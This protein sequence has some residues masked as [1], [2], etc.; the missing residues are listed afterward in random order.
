MSADRP[1]KLT[2]EEANEA[3]YLITM[4]CGDACPIVA[5]AM[6]DHWTM[7]D[8]KSRD[9]DHVRAIRDAIKTVYGS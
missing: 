4:G 2:S 8:P 5:G 9:L 3:S 7:D 1:R 6:R